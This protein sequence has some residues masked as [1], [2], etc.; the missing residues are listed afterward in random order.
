[1]PPLKRNEILEKKLQAIP[2]NNLTN[3]FL[4]PLFRCMGTYDKVEFHGGTNEEGKDVIFIGKDEIGDQIVDVV[5]VKRYKPTARASDD[6][7]FLE[8][9]RQLNQATTKKIP[10]ADG[11]EHLP[12][13]IYVVTPFPLD[14]RVIQTAFQE[15]QTLKYRV[16][17]ID[18]T[19]LANLLIT[20]LKDE[21]AD[22]LGRKFQSK[23]ALF[24]GLNNQLL[25]SALRYNRPLNLSEVYTDIDLI[26]G[27]I[28]TKMFFT[29]KFDGQSVRCTVEGEQWAQLK[30]SVA[31]AKKHLGIDALDKLP[32]EIERDEKRQLESYES[33]L[34]DLEKVAGKA[35]E[36][37]E[38]YAGHFEKKR[39]A[40]VAGDPNLKALHKE[41]IDQHRILD[42]YDKTRGASVTKRGGEPQARIDIRNKIEVLAA[43]IRVLERPIETHRKELEKADVFLASKRTAVARHK[44]TIPNPLH[45][46]VIRGSMLANT[47]RNESSWIQGKIKKYRVESPRRDELRKFLSRCEELF[48][49]TDALLEMPDIAR[50]VGVPPRQSARELRSLNRLPLTVDRIFDTNLNFCLLGEAGAGKTTTLM[51]AAK[52]RADSAPEDQAIFFVPLVS[53]IQAWEKKH[54]DGVGALETADD[55]ESAL[56]EFF[57]ERDS[58]VSPAEM[59]LH[60]RN[61]GGT[62]FLDGID[63]VIKMSPELPKAVRDLANRYPKVQFVVSSRM[64]GD[65]LRQ[66]P[67]LGITLLPFTPEQLRRFIQLSF[68]S[69]PEHSEK[70]VTILAHLKK[71]PE[72]IKVVRSPLLATILCVLAKKNVPLPDSEIQIYQERMRLLF[73]HYDHVKGIT[74]IL[75]PTDILD[76]VARKIAF[77]LHSNQIRYAQRD[78]LYVVALRSMPKDLSSATA[79]A[80]VDELIDPCNVL[81][82]MTSNGDFGFG[83]LRFQE[84]FAA[85]ELHSNPAL[86]I[87]SIMRQSNWRGPLILLAQLAESLDWLMERTTEALVVEDVFEN[88]SAMIDAGPI[89]ERARHR[90]IMKHYAVDAAVL[91]SGDERDDHE[92]LI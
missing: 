51:M 20:H 40:L 2:E 63:E 17:V 7:S 18:G 31:L 38:R 1:M 59:K 66:I 86:D 88:L 74:R 32:D 53:L 82:L 14:V 15:Y 68:V 69:E 85:S 80:V 12:R 45:H 64:S 73:G 75:T 79:K 58:S 83:H 72:L 35:N 5:Q 10:L 81:Q 78:D 24:S 91:D 27:R 8:I 13:K 52:R 36:V 56:A 29:S 57:I 25:T 47:L 46:I 43:R 22:L 42:N 4:I 21:V 3:K 6:K 11:T 34:S 84:Y 89:A 44:K 90:A 28:S 23:A 39:S 50:S 76:R 71:H 55:L 67:F 49:T 19:K 54:P 70:A 61:N 9:V 41:L 60:F 87:F 62:L 65:Y 37:R 26:L 33:K 30:T 77:Y 92:D 16:T 48:V